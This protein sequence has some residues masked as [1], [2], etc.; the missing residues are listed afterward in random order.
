MVVHVRKPN[1]CAPEMPSIA[2]VDAA[3]RNKKCELKDETRTR[4]AIHVTFITPYGVKPNAY[5]KN[6]QAFVTLNDLFVY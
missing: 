1:F 2:T 6:V 4:K 5:S 3:M